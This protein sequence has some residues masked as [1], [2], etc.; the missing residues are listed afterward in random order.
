V[1][2]AVNGIILIRL[3][4]R[5]KGV[6]AAGQTH[7]A[8]KQGGMVSGC[9]QPMAMQ[10]RKSGFAA[11]PSAAPGKTAADHA[12]HATC[13]RP[14]R[15]PKAGCM[16]RIAAGRLGPHSPLPLGEGPGVRAGSDGP[17]A[18]PLT[19]ALSRGEREQ[20]P[21]GAHVMDPKAKGA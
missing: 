21:S 9:P 5:V 14:G 20:E 8:A 10:A 3:A 1:R 17:R 2:S 15:R 18:F 11:W 7:V 12:T 19:P 13:V 4:G 16:A 6:W